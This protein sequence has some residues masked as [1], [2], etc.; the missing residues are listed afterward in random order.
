VNQ[1]ADIQARARRRAGINARRRADPRFKRVMGRYVQAGL[2]QTNEPFAPY[3]KP[4]RVADVLWAGEVEPRMLELLPALLIKK[5]ALFIDAQDIPA[6][7]ELAVRA[8]RRN[9]VPEPFRGVDGAALLKWLPLVGHKHKVPSQLKAFRM[10]KDDL[11]LL[12]RLQRQ[13]GGTQTMVLRRA[14]RALAS[15]QS[16]SAE[17]LDRE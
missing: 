7:L 12:E 17:S 8:L 10:Q 1:P 14:L 13:L 4:L 3:R 5:P 2:L 11:E 15:R 16:S 9:R 6:D